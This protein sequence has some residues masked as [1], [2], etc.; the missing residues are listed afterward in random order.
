MWS[1][2]AVAEYTSLIL[3]LSNN[4]LL[5]FTVDLTI[6]IS[7]FFKISLFIFTEF[8]YS[9][10]IESNPLSNRIISLKDFTPSSTTIFILVRLIGCN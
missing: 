8:R 7:T 5:T 4:N 3:V 1:L 6:K 2:P 10:S 9:N